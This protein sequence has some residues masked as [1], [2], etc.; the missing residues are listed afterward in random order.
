MLKIILAIAA[1]GA[2]GAVGRYALGGL[3]QAM[4]GAVFP[5]GTLAVNVLGCLLI[6]I[7]GAVFAGPHLVGEPWR[8]ALL[9]GLL[10]SFTTFSTFGWE[11]FELINDGQVARAGLNVLASVTLGLAAV[12]LGYRITEHWVG[13]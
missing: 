7:L 4:T 5:V 12:W 11:T 2:A 3:V 8:M 9:V 1:G 10:G 13:A 6:G